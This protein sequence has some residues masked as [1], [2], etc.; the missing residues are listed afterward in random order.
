M[1]AVSS[2]LL[3]VRPG[4]SFGYSDSVRFRGPR[5]GMP[6]HNNHWRTQPW[7][8]ADALPIACQILPI[9]VAVLTHC[10][11][12]VYLSALRRGK[13]TPAQ[14]AWQKF[15]LTGQALS[16]LDL[17]RVVP[18]H[19][20]GGRGWAG[21]KWGEKAGQQ[22]CLRHS[23]GGPYG[24]ARPPFPGSDADLASAL[25]LTRI[26]R[27]DAR[28]PSTRSRSRRTRLA[29]FPLASWSQSPACTSD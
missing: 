23:E 28:D 14:G 22:M 8:G 19:S 13:E 16:P 4:G 1:P 29:V 5:P 11:R 15:G 10:A 25:R 17:D 3:W 2:A 21:V 20:I 18:S 9:S 6:R 7:A 27:G 26:N 12:S 24:S